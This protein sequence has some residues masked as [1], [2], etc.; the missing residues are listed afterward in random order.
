M[1][2]DELAELKKTVRELQVRTS[3]EEIILKLLNTSL[4]ELRKQ[5]EHDEDWL[6]SVSQLARHALQHAEFATTDADVPALPKK[7]GER[8]IEVA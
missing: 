4:L 6:S 5:V 7:P 1:S 8:D 3:A 2:E